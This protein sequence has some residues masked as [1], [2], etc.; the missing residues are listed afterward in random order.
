[1]F[2]KYKKSIITLVGLAALLTFLTVTVY[3]TFYTFDNSVNLIESLGSLSMNN[4]VELISSY[5]FGVENI[6]NFIDFSNTTTINVSNFLFDSTRSIVPLNFFMQNLSTSISE[7]YNLHIYSGTQSTGHLINSAVASYS[8]FG[9]LLV[10]L[11]PALNLIIATVSEKKL[12]Q[13][14]S[15]EF[16]F[17]WTY[18]LIRSSQNILGLLSYNLIN[19]TLM[20]VSA[21]LLVLVSNKI[22]LSSNRNM[23]KIDE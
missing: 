1:M 18:I 16:A 12:Y 13:T 7:N 9:M 21:G 20:L 8:Y 23:V 19:I 3:K 5:F 11:L 14:R 17:I 6:A 4:I 10:W 22:T 15:Y 2:P